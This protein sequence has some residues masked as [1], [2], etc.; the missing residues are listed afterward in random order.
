M[1]YGRFNNR[2]EIRLEVKGNDYFSIKP[3]IWKYKQQ[4]KSK[5][6]RYTR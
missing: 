3:E 5:S 6:K 4:N 1:E 2:G